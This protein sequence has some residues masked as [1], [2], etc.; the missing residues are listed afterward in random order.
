MAGSL[1]PI[2]VLTTGDPDELY[3]DMRISC[4]GSITCLPFIG[5]WVRAAWAG[6]TGEEYFGER[7]WFTRVAQ[8][9]ASSINKFKKD[10]LSFEDI[11]KSLEI[12]AQGAGIPLEAIDTQIEA[13]GDYAQGDIAKGFLKTLGFSRYRAKKVTGED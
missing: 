10:E 8:I 3:T 6:V 5:E 2:T 1:S 7:D 11:L 12:F 4:L 9:T 13:V